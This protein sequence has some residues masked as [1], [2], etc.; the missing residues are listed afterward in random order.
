MAI[1]PTGMLTKKML[2]HD[3]CSTR[4]PPTMGPMASASAENAAQIP[5]AAPRS[6]PLNV[7]VMIESE[8][9]S[10]SAAP[11]PCTNRN[12][13]SS[14][15]VVDSPHMSEPKVKTIRPSMKKRLRP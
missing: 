3:T 7:A 11:R 1:A 8:P 6:R 12:P 9:G 15:V 14:P 4:N 13:T 2:C 10:S 5:M